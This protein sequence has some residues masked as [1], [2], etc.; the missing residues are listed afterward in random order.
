MTVNVPC[1]TGKLERAHIYLILNAALQLHI[2]CHLLFN[3]HI[4]S[5]SLQQQHVLLSLHIFVN[6]WLSKQWQIL[7]DNVKHEEFTSVYTCSS[8]SFKFNWFKVTFIS[9]NKCV[10]KRIMNSS[11]MSCIE[12]V[13]HGTRWSRACNGHA[14][15][16]LKSIQK[17]I[18]STRISTRYT[19]AKKNS[20]RTN[21]AIVVRKC[22]SLRAW[23]TL[24]QKA[25]NPLAPLALGKWKS[26]GKQTLAHLPLYGQ[27]NV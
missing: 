16:I 11:Q 17:Q 2:F 23:A 21:W 27:V 20:G 8:V 3:G 10:N 25:I 18:Q 9:F 12:E 7:K 19:T 22:E 13:R 4:Y 6:I 14:F 24:L 15:T 26:A 1:L 5:L